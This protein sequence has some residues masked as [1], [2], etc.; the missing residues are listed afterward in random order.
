MVHRWMG[1]VG[2]V[3]A[4]FSMA[5]THVL[6]IVF[7]FIQVGIVIGYAFLLY[8]LVTG[9]YTR[10]FSNGHR[11]TMFMLDLEIGL[12]RDKWAWFLSVMLG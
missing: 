3:R 5:F 10:C 12:R 11:G 1:V 4:A 2:Q 6:L 9:F 7:W 8:V